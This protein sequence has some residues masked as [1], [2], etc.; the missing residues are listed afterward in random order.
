MNLFK[1]MKR[2]TN[3]ADKVCK[4]SQ[5]TQEIIEKVNCPYQV[6]T[7]ENTISNVNKAYEKSL[8]EGKEKGFIPVLVVSD[9]TMA[10]WL[11][12]LEDESYSKEDIVAQERK[13][14]K[15]IL[16]ERFEEYTD[17]IN[18]IIDDSESNEKD[19][20]SELMGEKK[21]GETLLELTSFQNYGGDGIQETI[22][23]EIP[24]NNPWEVIAWLPIGG[25]N[26]CPEASE[27]ME[28]CRYWYEQYGAV[29]SVISHDTLEFTV[30]KVVEDEDTAWK[31][32]KE[33]YAFCNDRVDQA[34][35]N[36]TIGEVADCISKSKVWFFWWD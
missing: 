22:L 19:L 21:G 26:D 34:T 17:Y 13:D 24:V 15:K 28:V 18:N 9:D 12:I 6:F 4:Y 33:H 14:A 23:F 36:G 29:P 10:E 32:A 11:G 16:Q 20:M 5:T 2:T 7:E 30:E 35:A 3:E 1:K 31:L 8:I 27:M 25:W